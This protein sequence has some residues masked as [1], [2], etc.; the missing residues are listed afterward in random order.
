MSPALQLLAVTVV[1]VPLLAA[2]TGWLFA[3]REPDGIARRLHE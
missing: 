3:G 1:G 2:A